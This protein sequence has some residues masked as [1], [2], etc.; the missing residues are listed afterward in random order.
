MTLVNSK[1]KPR[2]ITNVAISPSYGS[3][4]LLDLKLSLNCRGPEAKN[5]NV[6]K[7]L[8]LTSVKKFSIYHF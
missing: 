8:S 1:T 7:C 6:L 3:Q 4:K 5:I 2:L